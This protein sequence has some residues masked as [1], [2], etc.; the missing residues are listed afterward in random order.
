MRK[1][2]P[3]LLSTC[4]GS[5]PV[6]FP[7]SLLIGRTVVIFQCESPSSPTIFVHAPFFEQ[8]MSLLVSG[9]R[10]ERTAR[11]YFHLPSLNW[12]GENLFPYEDA[13]EQERQ[14]RL[15]LHD[16]TVRW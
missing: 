8:R 7:S 1:I 11:Q 12:S 2:P 14:E 5:P 9:E 3:H 6:T 4:C 16:L 15:L 13:E 10:Q